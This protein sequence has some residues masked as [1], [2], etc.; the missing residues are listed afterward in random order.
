VTVISVVELVNFRRARKN[1][2]CTMLVIYIVSKAFFEKHGN[3]TCRSI[4]SDG[5]GFAAGCGL[6]NQNRAE[7]EHSTT[8]LLKVSPCHP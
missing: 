6:V 2:N 7:Q 5:Y 3:I 4:G 1:L 8:G